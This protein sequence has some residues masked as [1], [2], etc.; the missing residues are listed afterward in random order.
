MDFSEDKYTPGGF[1]PDK[2]GSLD[3][4]ELVNH[5]WFQPLFTGLVNMN[6]Q[7]RGPEGMGYQN[8]VVSARWLC[9]HIPQP[10]DQDFCLT[11]Y[12]KKQFEQGEA[13]PFPVRCSAGQEHWVLLQGFIP[14]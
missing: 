7:K 5:G 13:V 4:G 1:D 11:P 9:P 6:L 2:H 8:G 14:S 3:V 12:Y 10:E